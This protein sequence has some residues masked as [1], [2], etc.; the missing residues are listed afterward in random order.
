M[1]PFFEL[2]RESGYVDEVGGERR[3]VVREVPLPG[4]AA[5]VVVAEHPA[6]SA[7]VLQRHA[8]PSG[9]QGKVTFYLSFI[10]LHKRSK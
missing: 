4:G 1:R 2:R 10:M 5:L 3:V 7:H 6:Q 8:V 9:L